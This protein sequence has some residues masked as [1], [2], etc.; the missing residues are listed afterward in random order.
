[1][2]AD[3][4]AAG[5][6]T[7]MREHQVL[8]KGFSEIDQQPIILSSLQALRAAGITDIL[9]VAGYGAEHYQALAQQTG[10]FQ[11]IINP[12]YATTS[13][14]Y[15]LYCAKDWIDSDVL[16]LESDIIYDPSAI[17]KLLKD[18][19]PNATIVSELSDVGDEVYVEANDHFLTRMSK[20]KDH[21][22]TEKVIGEFVGINKL[23]VTACQE[24]FLL[25]AEDKPLLE[26][27]H[28]EE[29]G[30]IALTKH[31][32]IYCLKLNNFRWCEIDCQEQLHKAQA[33]F[34]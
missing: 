27:G 1:M 6:G 12:H 10:F 18:P 19:H 32:P 9:L 29:D 23:S 17:M 16:V 3:I 7:R 25:L 14:L 2:K 15:S 31:Q 21:L 34:V 4:L 28:Y 11:T 8:P 5:M 22:Q 30:M 24:L 13:S 33:L 26:N 20:H